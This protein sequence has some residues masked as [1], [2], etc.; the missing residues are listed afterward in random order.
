MRRRTCV[1]CWFRRRAETIFSLM[2]VPVRGNKLEQK[3]AIARTRSPGTRDAC[4]TQDANLC[5]ECA[6]I[7][8]LL[9][10]Q[11][12]RRL[13]ARPFP[14]RWL[15]LIQRHVVFFGRLSP[16]DRAELLRH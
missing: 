15:A 9:K 10:Q 5:L 13:R 16:S 4:A 2:P 12:R 3:S 1:A 8:S 6:V 7:F 11:R 14:K